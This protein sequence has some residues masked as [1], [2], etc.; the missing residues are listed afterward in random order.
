VLHFQ[1]QPALQV[2]LQHFEIPE[3]G[4][5]TGEDWGGWSPA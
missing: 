4:V 3:G 2:F 1:M 5:F